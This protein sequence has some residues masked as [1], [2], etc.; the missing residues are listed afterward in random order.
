MNKEIETLSSL[1]RMLVQL[2]SISYYPL[3][4]GQIQLCLNAWIQT[5]NPMQSQLSET[6]LQTLIEPLSQLGLLNITGLH[7]IQIPPLLLEGIAH[8]L[9]LPNEAKELID[10]LQQNLGLE[11]LQADKKPK[12]FYEGIRD[13]RWALYSHRTAEF[14]KLINTLQNY[15]PAEFRHR[16]P[17]FSLFDEP[18]SPTAFNQWP[19]SFALSVAATIIMLRVNRMESCTGALSWLRDEA[20]VAPKEQR[21]W[22]ASVLSEPLVVQG[23]LT[24]ALELAKTSDGEILFPIQGL[25]DVLGAHFEKAEHFF[26]TYLECQHK[27]INLKKIGMSGLSG[28]SY[29]ISLIVSNTPKNLE[30][31]S[32]HIAQV[33]KGGTTLMNVYAH[34]GEVAHASSLLHK[35][36]TQSR[37]PTSTKDPLGVLFSHLTQWWIDADSESWDLVR[38][39]EYAQLAETNGYR[40]LASEFWALLSVEDN[41]VAQKRSEHIHYELGTHTLLHG[42]KPQAIWERTLTSLERLRVDSLLT[43]E[44][45]SKK[46][47]LAWFLEWNEGSQRFGILAKEFKRQGIA[48]GS[49]AKIVSWSKLILPTFESQH[50]L[51]EADRDLIQ[52]I[53]NI[54]LLSKNI[55]RRIEDE[56]LLIYLMGHPHVYINDTH[57]YPVL[58]KRRAIWLSLKKESHQLLLATEP[59]IPHNQSFLVQRECSDRLVIYEVEPSQ[60]P[61]VALLQG[62]EHVFPLESE[63]RLL[64]V[65]QALSGLMPFYSELDDTYQVT[66]VHNNDIYALLSPI[67]SGLEMELMVYPEGEHQEGYRPGIGPSWIIAANELQEN[68]PH[69]LLRSVS[70]ERKKADNIWKKFSNWL[71]IDPVSHKYSTP[72][73]AAACELLWALKESNDTLLHLRWPK[74][75]TLKLSPE[76][77]RKEL[78]IQLEG[79][80]DWLKIQ[81]GLTVDAQTVIELSEL[82]RL[83]SQSK[84][85]FI[86]LDQRHFIALSQDL[87]NKIREMGMISEPDQDGLRL[88]P[89]MVTEL[90]QMMDTTDADLMKESEEGSHVGYYLK[91]HEQIQNWSPPVPAGLTAVLRDYQIQGF[92]WMIRLSEIQAG[93]CLADDMGL[94]KT[95]Q[96]LAVLLYRSETGPALVVAPTSVC[97]N[98]LSEALKFAPS[99]Q[100]QWLT[101]GAD[102]P[103]LQESKMGQ[104]WIISYNLFQQMSEELLQEIHWGTVVLDEAQNIKNPLTKRSQTAMKLKAH[105]RLV[106]T[107]TPIENHLGELWNLFRFINPGLLGSHKSFNERFAIPI[108]R[109]GNLEIL[110]HLKQLISPFILRR[111]KEQVLVELP[112]RT[113]ITLVLAMNEEERNLYEAVRQEALNTVHDF[114]EQTESSEIGRNR[115][116]ILASLMKMRRACCHGKLLVPDSPWESSKLVA[117]MDIIQDL[118]ASGHRALIFS[119]FVDYLQII[120][121][122]MEQQKIGFQYLDGST[123]AGERTKRV[124]MFQE[125]QDAV[126]LISLKAGGVGL[127]L[128]GADYVIHMDP[129]WN[130]AVED[131]ASD[132]AHRY[133]QTKPVTI[134]RL[135]CK[136]TIEEKILAL[137]ERKR[138]LADSLLEG[139]EQNTSLNLDDLKELLN[140][141]L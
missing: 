91:V 61:I 66:P 4:L 107:G 138:G 129:W 127:N 43:K 22:F 57:E 64:H 45:P 81:G 30:R 113:E 120:K 14:N 93:A 35:N 86:S 96:T 50:E 123:P 1:Q 130:P 131:Q 32:S 108:Q 126:F 139:A 20:R 56:S 110:N 42:M 71:K 105:F 76:V 128:T 78:Q 125:G 94:G 104:V 141:D 89:L 15:F 12:T 24:E 137:H 25:V 88:H 117:L 38:L 39:Q 11:L 136:N 69:L 58:L 70:L 73:L 37:V 97:G 135:I 49:E 77:T 92:E 19:K 87:W 82:V 23:Y 85:R 47:R 31:A 36:T 124:K 55:D 112:E 51:M 18:F 95:I 132:R 65:I 52:Q 80:G 119:Q 102:W 9:E 90:S 54:A 21:Q 140:E 67:P 98:W 134:Y 101:Q 53:K 26:S 68:K 10:I 13:L 6:D 72:T 16:N 29:V 3:S 116:R 41:L 74:G 133:G 34:L 75:E 115:L 7:K 121:T 48:T 63:N 17:W 103:L 44:A 27:P 84:N 8:T 33:I 79:E 59:I 28:V 106:T 114:Q 99:L 118:V 62:Q 46:Y 5:K 111:T 100:V 60:K 40:W 83:A 109:E 122:L 2:L